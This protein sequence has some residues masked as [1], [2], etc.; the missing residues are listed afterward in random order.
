M[1]EIWFVVHHANLWDID[2]KLIGF[3]K[4]NQSDL[5]KTGDYVIYYRT[6]YKEIMGIFKVAQKGYRLNREFNDPEIAEEPVY[7]SKLELVSDSIICH[8]PTV[9]TR[10]SFF[11]E[12]R[13]NRFGGLGK[14]VFRASKDDLTLLLSDPSVV[15]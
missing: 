1:A 8:R 11:D 9:E 15:K 7:Q 5:I 6:G 14:Q 10:F 3:W 2:D 13:R 12:W 4:K